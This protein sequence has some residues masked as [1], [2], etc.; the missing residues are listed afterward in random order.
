MTDIPSTV[1]LRL[2]GSHPKIEISRSQQFDIL[3]GHSPPLYL[4]QRASDPVCFYW[5]MCGW[6]LQEFLGPTAAAFQHF[7]VH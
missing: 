4:S 3:K 1:S 5:L 7:C 2:V 6:D